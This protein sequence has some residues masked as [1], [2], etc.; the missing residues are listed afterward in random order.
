M[1]VRAKVTASQRSAARRSVEQIAVLVLL[2]WGGNAIAASPPDFH[3]EVWPILRDRCVI[4]H[5]PDKVKG[6]LRLDSRAEAASGGYSGRSLLSAPAAENELVQ[7]I[8]SSD[9]ELRMPPE[10]EPL[11]P[12]QV[13]VIKDWI[14][15]GA[16]WPPAWEEDSAK[17]RHAPPAPL[18]D[19]LLDI[20]ETTR[21]AWFAALASAVLLAILLAARRRQAVP[22]QQA[23]GSNSR[24]LERTARVPLSVPVMGFFAAVI[25][26]MGQWITRLNAQLER[27]AARPRL[28]AAALAEAAPTFPQLIPQH[29]PRLGGEY[30]RGN[31]ERSE[32]LF[33]GGFYRTATLNL[34]LIDEEGDVLAWGDPCPAQPRIEFRLAR[35]AQATK[36]LFTER[37]LGKVRLS[38]IPPHEFAQVAEDELIPLEVLDP[39]DQWRVVYPVDELAASGACRGHLF[40]YSDVHHTDG[41]YVGIPGYRIDYDLH[42]EDGEIASQST[43]RL[44]SLERTPRLVAA[45]SPGDVSAEQWFDFRPIPEIEGEPATDEELLGIPQHTSPNPEVSGAPA[46]PS[47]TES[48]RNLHVRGDNEGR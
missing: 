4:C 22:N 9:A 30:Y 44:V 33:N 11:T 38:H 20:V 31:D 13:E 36:A 15:S 39:G 1:Q 23:G 28:V 47:F 35:A 7:R 12:E 34:H 27:A 43:L 37:I 3:R 6:G 5:G 16:Y 26:G 2:L 8:E 48:S 41:R 19:R 25:L 24:W 46:A 14:N 10:G 42:L 17:R 32:R 45:R 40:L 29:P 21:A 18:F